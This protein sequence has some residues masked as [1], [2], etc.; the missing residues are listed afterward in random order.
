MKLEW[1]EG[2]GPATT[3]ELANAVERERRLIT[4]RCYDKNGERCLWGVIWN[5]HKPWIGRPWRFRRPW[6]QRRLTLECEKFLWRSG[7]GPLTND[8]FRGTP[9][10]RCAA[11]VTILRAIP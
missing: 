9:E 6:R 8:C 7:L 3:Q 10:E 1:K 5:F 2:K 4:L 11:M